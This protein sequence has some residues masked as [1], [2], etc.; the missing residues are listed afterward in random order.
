RAS[1]TNAVAQTRVSHK[2][3]NATNDRTAAHSL[4]QA[5]NERQTKQENAHQGRADAAPLADGRQEKPT[6]NRSALPRNEPAHAK[7][8]AAPNG[9]RVRHSAVGRVAP[10]AGRAPRVAGARRA[11]P[12]DETRNRQA[13][14]L[15][16]ANRDAA[17]THEQADRT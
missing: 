12:G 13:A 3:G 14:G 15:G 7:H 8:D 17:R 2:H 4:A 11:S 1:K 10:G 16:G 6:A 5:Q 9:L